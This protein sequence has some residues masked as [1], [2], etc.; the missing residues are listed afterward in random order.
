MKLICPHCGEKV[1]KWDYI[2]HKCAPSTQNVKPKQEHKFGFVDWLEEWW[3]YCIFTPSFFG[4]KLSKFDEENEFDILKGLLYNTTT[5]ILP[6][7]IFTLLG[8]DFLL[9]DLGVAFGLVVLISP[10]YLIYFA[11]KFMLKE[12]DTFFAIFLSGQ[13]MIILF[14]I[15]LIFGLM[16]WSM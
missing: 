7:W 4:T 16:M 6:I 2:D 13:I 9:G 14:Y 11:W 12:K 8:S 10:P 1:R 15:L 3:R 5:I